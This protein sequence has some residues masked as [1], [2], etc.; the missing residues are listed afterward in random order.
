MARQHVHLRIPRSH[1]YADHFPAM[2]NTSDNSA[3]PLNPTSTAQTFTTR[4]IPA[5]MKISDPFGR[6]DP[7]EDEAAGNAVTFGTVTQ[8][9]TTVPIIVGRRQ[10]GFSNLGNVD[11][12]PELADP[13][14]YPAGV[15][16]HG[17]DAALETDA[18]FMDK[19]FEYRI[20]TLRPET[21]KGDA[22]YEVK[23]YWIPFCDIA[24]TL[25][26]KI[27]NCLLG[28]LQAFS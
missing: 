15:I 4:Y 5:E 7:D 25:E 18:T 12:T 10:R 6:Y 27:S 17:N 24:R 28:E 23:K 1:V 20:C 14:L 16:Y 8:G 11:E 2:K 3:L 21:L 26:S 13:R 19:I 9:Q 22:W